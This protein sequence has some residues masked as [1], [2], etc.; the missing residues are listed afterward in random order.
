MK[1]YI[2]RFSICREGQAHSPNLFDTDNLQT[3]IMWSQIP[4][5]VVLDR[6]NNLNQI[7]TLDGVYYG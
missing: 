2:V 4:N 1:R 6:E 5:I 3:A 7:V